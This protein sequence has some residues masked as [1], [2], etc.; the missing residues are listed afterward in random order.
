MLVLL[1]FLFCL[2]VAIDLDV[3]YALV[4]EEKRNKCHVR[5]EKG[6]ND[7]RWRGD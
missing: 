1:F 2:A 6:A 5:R 3:I 7:E 4:G